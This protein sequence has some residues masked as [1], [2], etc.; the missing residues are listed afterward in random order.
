MADRSVD[1]TEA[2]DPGADES[3]ALTLIGQAGR[4]VGVIGGS[5]GIAVALNVGIGSGIGIVWPAVLGL[6]GIGGGIGALR[7]RRRAVLAA[8]TVFVGALLLGPP[9]IASAVHAAGTFLIGWALFIVDQ[10]LRQHRSA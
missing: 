8:G 3:A 1:S 9:E 10:L 5:I 7:C 2:A 4:F 6:A